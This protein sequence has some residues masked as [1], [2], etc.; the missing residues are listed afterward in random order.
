MLETAAVDC[1]HCGETAAVALDPSEGTHT[2]VE[3]CSVC[4][5]PMVVSVGMGPDGATRVT[6]RR[7]DD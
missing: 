3:D 7:E 2:R 1:P 4:C 5:S 6:V